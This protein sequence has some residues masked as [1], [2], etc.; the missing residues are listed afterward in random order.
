MVDDEATLVL[1]Y[2]GK[3][4]GTIVLSTGEGEI[5]KRLEI[6][7][8]EGRILLE[9]KRLSVTRFDRDIRSYARG[10][11]VMGRQQLGMTTEQLEFEKDETAYEA[12][13]RNFESAIHHQT[14]LIAPGG[15]GIATLS[16]INGAYLSAWE[17]RRLALPVDDRRYLAALREREAMEKADCDGGREA[18]Q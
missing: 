9:D 10:A 16:L 4:T 13:L 7:G 11:Q 8:T 17:G 15:D 12:M 2:P 5:A 18:F 1:D 14:P 3:V 6:V